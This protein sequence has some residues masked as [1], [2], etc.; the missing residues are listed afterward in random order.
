[1][2]VAEVDDG[3]IHTLQLPDEIS[4]RDDAYHDKENKKV[5]VRESGY[6]L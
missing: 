6:E 3:Y 5:G 4:G 1:M 2:D